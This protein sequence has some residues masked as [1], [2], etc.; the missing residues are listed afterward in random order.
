[1]AGALGGW[2]AEKIA[3]LTD[4]LMAMNE[5]L[6]EALGPQV[7]CHAQPNGMANLGNES[8]SREHAR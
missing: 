5:G 8:A 1:M 2:S 3:E 7:H 4:L 6:R